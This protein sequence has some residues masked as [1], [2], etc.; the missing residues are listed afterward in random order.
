L[1]LK[2]IKRWEMQLVSPVWNIVEE[3]N[4]LCEIWII[5]CRT[6]ISREIIR[7]ENSKHTTCITEIYCPLYSNLRKD[8]LQLCGI[9]ET[10][11]CEKC[12]FFPGNVEKVSDWV[13]FSVNCGVNG[14]VNRQNTS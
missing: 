13:Q 9:K 2:R 3:F 1:Y 11:W 4:Y 14:E 7:K 8:K 5:S 6:K 12:E 10:R